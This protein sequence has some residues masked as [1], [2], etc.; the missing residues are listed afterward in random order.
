MIKSSWRDYAL[1]VLL[2]TL[3]GASYSFIRIGVET[4]PPATFIAAR[5]LIAGLLLALV[6]IVRRVDV[7]RN[8]ALMR[9]FAVQAL[10]NSVVPFTLI[11]WG[12]RWVDA[13]VA[14]MLNAMTPVFAFVLGGIVLRREPITVRRTC[15]VILGVLGVAVITGLGSMRAVGNAL[16]PQLAIITASLFYA[17]GA[18]Y[19]KRFSHLDPIVPAGGSLLIGSLLLMPVALAV[20][21]P[22]TLTPSIAS[23]IALL[24]LATL[25]TAVAFVIYF[26]LVRTIGAVGT[27][28]QSFLRVPIGVAFGALAL[29]ESLSWNAWIGFVMIVAGVAALT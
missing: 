28:T 19:G 14:T 11:A 5:T 20:D 8:P 16:L 9:E 17:C 24:G 22:W 6:A 29:H 4:I 3:W 13:G 2:A 10:F 18:I 21:R 27:T 25:S 23:L 26:H 1:L 7:P 12:E 15:G